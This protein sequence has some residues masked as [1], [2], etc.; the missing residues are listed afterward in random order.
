VALLEFSDA[1]VETFAC[2][3][4]A[5]LLADAKPTRENAFKLPLVE[6]TL[7]SVLADAKG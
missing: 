6:R 5:R 2:M 4:S 1:H 7:A 3:T